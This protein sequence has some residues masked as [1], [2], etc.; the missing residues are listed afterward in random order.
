ME[1]ELARQGARQA[2]LTGAFAGGI[3]ADS[4]SDYVG[5]AI[6]ADSEVLGKI[7]K[8]KLDSIGAGS[9]SFNNIIEGSIFSGMQ[10]NPS[11]TVDAID[12]AV[13]TARVILDDA[14]NGKI[15]GVTL[16]EVGN[17]TGANQVAN[18]LS[19]NIYFIVSS[20]IEGLDGAIADIEPSADG[21]GKYLVHSVKPI[22]TKG[23]G[24]VAD[25]TEITPMTAGSVMAS[26]EREEQQTFVTDTLSYTFN[27]KK[28]ATDANNYEMEKGKNSVLVNGV[29]LN[30]FSVE[31]GEVNP[32]RSK[33]VDGKT[34][35]ATFKYTAGQITLTISDNIDAG[36]LIMFSGTLSTKKQE[37]VTGKI[38]VDIE[39][40][41]YVGRPVRIATTAN[42][43]NGRVTLTEAGV[44]INSMGLGQ[45]IQKVAEEIKAKKVAKAVA[46]AKQYGSTINLSNPDGKYA[47]RVEAYKQIAVEVDNALAEI[48]EASSLGGAGYI[49]GGL[50]FEKLI[51]AL[52]DKNNGIVTPANDNS[53]GIRKLGMLNEKQK[54][55]YIPNFDALYP[56]GAEGEYYML[57][58]LSPADPKKR[59]VLSGTGL[60]ILPEKSAVDTSGNEV[61]PISGQPI[62]EINK[63]ANSRQLVRK[64]RFKL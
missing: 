61:I 44:N 32:T 37:D 17:I 63:D 49:Y 8:V 33:T 7:G 16:D 24:D 36:A 2:L 27:L 15:K 23:M 26:F 12:T 14:Y 40:Q 59:A 53:N 45:I 31:S 1:K 19:A 9:V 30:D 5:R 55:L 47:T 64:I 20:N 43:L 58:V 34:Y 50:G 48:R 35:T 39:P 62:V 29:E 38:E 21:K 10:A 52:S 56:T 18:L 6:S 60:A 11:V 28:I 51:N 13:A 46:L 3:T 42:S 4:V 41:T 22:A 57:V 54:A 25:G